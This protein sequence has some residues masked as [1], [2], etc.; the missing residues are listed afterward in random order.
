MYNLHSNMELLLPVNF[1]FLVLLFSTFTFQYGATSTALSLVCSLFQ[2]KFTFQ[3]G[4]TSTVFLHVNYYLILLFTFQY[5]ATST[6][7][8]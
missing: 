6:R 3:Y 5:G 2:S 8:S 4:A 1:L 7:R